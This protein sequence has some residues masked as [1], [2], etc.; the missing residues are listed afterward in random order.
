MFRNE[1]VVFKISNYFSNENREY[2]KKKIKI[3]RGR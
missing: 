3:N 1:L 2:N